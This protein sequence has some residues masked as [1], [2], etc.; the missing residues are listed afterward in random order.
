MD[1]Q[2]ENEI[3]SLFSRLIKPRDDRLNNLSRLGKVLMM[4]AGNTQSAQVQTANNEIADNVKFIEAYGF[5]AKPKQNSEC[6]LL[7][8]Q[9]NPGNVVALVIG[10]RELRFKALNDGEVAMYDDSG[11]LL[12]FKNGGV[13]DFK[14][15]A[16]MNQTAQTINV[17]GTTAVNVNTQTA[18]VTAKTLNVE[19]DTAAIKA[20]TATVD[21]QTT[22]VNGKVNL[23]GGGQPVARLG[24]AVQ[25]NVTSGSSAGTWSGTI[26]AGSTEV[27]AG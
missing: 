9:G 26:T 11:N 6:I 8:I 18:A 25:V 27:T 15:P 17:S 4:K 20:K 23:A 14:A 22:T 12:H 10:N 21:A 24:D 7:N 16:T 5:T 1:K 19:A 13:I 2:L 3:I